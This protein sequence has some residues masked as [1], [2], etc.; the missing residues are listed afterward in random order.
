IESLVEE[1]ES[2]KQ[3]EATIEEDTCTLFVKNLNFDTTDEDLEKHFSSIGPCRA[4][5]AKKK[6]PKRPGQLL[7][8]GYG[9]IEYS[10]MKLLNEAL[11]QLQHSQLHEHQ[12]ELKR[13]ERTMKSNQEIKSNKR[14]RQLEKE[15]HTSKILVKNIPFQANIKEI[16]ELFRVFGE[17]KFVRMPK[18][19]DDEHH[20]GFGFVDFVSKNDAKNAFEALCHSTHLYGRRLVLEWADEEN[21]TVEGLRKKTAAEFDLSSSDKRL[22]RSELLGE[23]RKMGGNDQISE[24]KPTEED[25]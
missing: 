3:E 23:L 17:L 19:I 15:Q 6:D 5:V 7:S 24:K 1:K 10:S 18:K 14:K 9:F 20:R 12:L 22:K 2:D 13:S 25:E 8:M 4:Y 11:K 21:D 16:R